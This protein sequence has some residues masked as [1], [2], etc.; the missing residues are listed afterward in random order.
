MDITFVPYTLFAFTYRVSPIDLIFIS[1]QYTRSHFFS[2]I[3]DAS[4]S[5]LAELAQALE[6]YYGVRN[7]KSALDAINGFDQNVYFC[8]LISALKR[9]K[10]KAS[11]MPV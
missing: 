6:E 7:E 5:S 3:E 4:Q 8:V 9:A 2:V 1:E 11:N 10:G